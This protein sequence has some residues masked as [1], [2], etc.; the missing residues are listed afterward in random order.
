MEEQENQTELQC[1]KDLLAI[2]KARLE[3]ETD[4]LLRE[5]LKCWIKET[6]TK[7][8]MHTWEKLGKL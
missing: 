5:T 1:L 2:R 8:S 4:P 7:I 6:E 3:N